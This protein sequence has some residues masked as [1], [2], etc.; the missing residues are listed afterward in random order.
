MAI[1]TLS[2]P[3]MRVMISR[4]LYERTTSPTSSRRSTAPPSLD[5]T[6]ALEI[7][8]AQI[9]VDGAD[10]ELGLAFAQP[11]AG[12]V[13][14]LLGQPLGDL[15][16][17]NALAGQRALVDA[18]LDLFFE[19]A[20]D[21]R[22]GDALDALERALDALFA[23]EPQPDQIV[24]AGQARDARSDRARGRSAAAAAA[25]RPAAAAARRA[26]RARR[27]RRD[28]CPCPTRTRA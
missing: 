20:G 26:A 22:G 1:S 27:A 19:A 18:H 8:G 14:V 21:D 2:R 3:S 11:A 5:S 23:G 4:S 10:Q 12:Q 6:H 17:R 16:D 7:G 13:D 24:V 28:P 9:L 15:R 25:R